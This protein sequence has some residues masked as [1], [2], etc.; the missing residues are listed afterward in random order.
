V[1]EVRS[2][3]VVGIYGD[4]YRYH[5]NLVHDYWNA[6]GETKTT[7]RRGYCL[8]LRW[9]A[10]HFAA[11]LEE[12]AGMT[13]PLDPSGG[14]ILD[15]TVIFWHNEFGHDGHDNQHTRHPAIVAGGEAGLTVQMADGQRRDAETIADTLVL[16]HEPGEPS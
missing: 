14:S 3:G 10:G 2:S 11:V 4:T 16:L 5:E 15:N 8:G 13:D 1:P 7:L 12:L 9:A 6:S